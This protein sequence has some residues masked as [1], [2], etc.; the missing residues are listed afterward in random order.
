MVISPAGAVVRVAD[1]KVLLKNGA[2]SASECS[3]VFHDGVLYAIPGGARAVRLVPAGEDA[4][5]LAKVWEAK[6]AGGRG[7]PSP[8]LHEGLLYAVN[9]DG[10]LEVLDAATGAMVYKQR[11]EIGSMYSSVTAAAGY[12]YLGSTCAA[13]PSCCAGANTAK[14]P[15]TSS[16]APAARRSSAADGCTALAAAFVLHWKLSGLR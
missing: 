2:L 4:V 10:I 5:K 14:W 12:L 15:A 9:T 6:T 3:P 8:V 1:G 7:T 16:K 11:L 13:Q